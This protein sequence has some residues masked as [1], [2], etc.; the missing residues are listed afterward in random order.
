MSLVAARRRCRP[1]GTTSVTGVVCVA[2]KMG[3][4]QGATKGAYLNRYV[5]EEQ[6]SRRPIFIATTPGCESFGRL[7]VVIGQR[8]RGL[9]GLFASRIQPKYAQRHYSS[10]DLVH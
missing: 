5:T 4:R 7:L 8:P 1:L 6:R 10:H 3:R 9:F 2:I